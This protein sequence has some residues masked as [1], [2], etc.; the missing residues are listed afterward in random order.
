MYRFKGTGWC[1][2]VIWHMFYRHML[3]KE[4]V[5]KAQVTEAQVA[6]RRKMGNSTSWEKAQVGKQHRLRRHKLE[7]C[8]WRMLTR[9]KLEKGTS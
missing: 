6:K 2:P 3:T 5:S 4:H 7:K 1:S 8:E 9:H